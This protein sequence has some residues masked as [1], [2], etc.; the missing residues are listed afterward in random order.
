MVLWSRSERKRLPSFNERPM[1]F[2]SPESGSC[3]IRSGEL[4]LKVTV[5]SQPWSDKVLRTSEHFRAS[6]RGG[7]E[8]EVDRASTIALQLKQQRV[9][10]RMV[11]A[12]LHDRRFFDLRAVA[13]EFLGSAR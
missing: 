10:A 4:P 11:S 2:R 9:S 1:S 12:W 13:V 8:G 5:L 7:T 3:R 6:E